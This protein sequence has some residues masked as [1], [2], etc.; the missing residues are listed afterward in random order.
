MVLRK[1]ERQIGSARAQEWLGWAKLSV[2]D[3]TKTLKFAL[4]TMRERPG[5]TSPRIALTLDSA[6]PLEDGS[7][8]KTAITKEQAIQLWDSIVD[9]MHPIHT[10]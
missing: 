1:D 7:P 5:K 2:G 9:S 6:Q 4:E 10:E 3:D 8:T